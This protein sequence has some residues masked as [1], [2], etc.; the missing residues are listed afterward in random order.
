MHS[1]APQ[2]FLACSQVRSCDDTHDTHDTHSE[3]GSCNRYVF[4]CNIYQQLICS[5]LAAAACLISLVVKESDNVKFIVLD[6]LDAFR[7]RHGHLLD[8][9]I[10]DVLQVLSSA[11]IE[12]RRK[13]MAIVL[14]MTSSRN[15]EEVVLFLKKQLLQTQ[16]QDFEKV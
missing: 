2:Y 12:V 4:L 14:S 15:V 6:R 5:R 10:M 11:D 3:S 16:D 7:S 9:L 1:R 13:A 8:G